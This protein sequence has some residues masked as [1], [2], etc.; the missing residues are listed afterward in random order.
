VR[1]T[2]N[3]A[4]GCFFG[5]FVKKKKVKIKKKLFQSMLQYGGTSA[6]KVKMGSAKINWSLNIE[7]SELLCK[8]TSQDFVSKTTY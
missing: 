6:R 2:F 3:L 4:R 5:F 8:L 7:L 1:K